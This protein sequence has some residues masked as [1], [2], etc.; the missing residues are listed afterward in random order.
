MTDEIYDDIA[1]ER[2][3]KERFG[4]SLDISQVVVRGIPVSRTAHATVFFDG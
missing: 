4:V 3:S 2:F 1:L